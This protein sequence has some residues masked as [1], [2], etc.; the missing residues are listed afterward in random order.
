MIVD[1]TYEVYNCFFFFMGSDL[2]LF[3]R[4]RF[5]VAFLILSV[6]WVLYPFVETRSPKMF[7]EVEYYLI[8]LLMEIGG[9][10]LWAIGM[11]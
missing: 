3:R 6:T 11:M 8:S 1:H 2:N 5:R 4:A 10:R 7:P 9:L